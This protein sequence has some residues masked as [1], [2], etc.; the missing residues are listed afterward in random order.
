[1]T[2]FITTTL[3]NKQCFLSDLSFNYPIKLIPTGHSEAQVANHTVYCSGYG[4]GLVS[5][6]TYK[7]SVIVTKDTCLTLLTQGATKV[8]K[9]RQETLCNSSGPATQLN[10]YT[11]NDA[12]LVLLPDVI[13]PFSNSKFIQQHLLHL[14]TSSNLLLLDW[15]NSGPSKDWNFQFK[16]DIQM[17]YNNQ[18]V[19]KDCTI[20]KHSSYHVF[21]TLYIIG[22]LFE[23]LKN[24]AVRLDK[25]SKVF[26]S[27]S[28]LPHSVPGIVIKAAA[29][30]SE[31]IKL[32]VQQIIHGIDKIIGHDLFSRIK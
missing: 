4:G 16:S 24:N 19:I 3:F 10:N 5:G 15:F 23:P 31:P 17:Y 7:L 6:D 13:I 2:A 14:N 26:W 29:M 1:M 21:A 25:H 30:E 22:S 9:L 27:W 18:L 28:P 12:T 20:I 32:L 8:F 11:L